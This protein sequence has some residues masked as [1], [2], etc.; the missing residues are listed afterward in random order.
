MALSFG[1]FLIRADAK[2]L[3]DQVARPDFVSAHPQVA[4]RNK[5]SPGMGAGAFKSGEV[6]SNQ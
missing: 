1:K 3:L 5:K 6:R 2:T 4:G